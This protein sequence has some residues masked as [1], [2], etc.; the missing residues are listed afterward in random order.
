MLFLNL[1]YSLYWPLTCNP[2]ASASWVL[3]LQVNGIV[4]GCQ[5]C[6][7]TTFTL[8]FF[9]ELVIKSKF[10]C[11]LCEC[12][13]H[14]TPLSH[15]ILVLREGLIKLPCLSWNKHNLGWCQPFNALAP[16]S[17]VSGITG[18][19]THTQLACTIL[20]VLWHLGHFVFVSHAY[21]YL[22]C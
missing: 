12:Y 8:F 14:A 3:G 13:C 17:A 9:L 7:R 20:N 1:L 11:L 10:P 15:F 2:P 18:L 5:F 19:C 16:V 6:F 22:A 4:L 21:W